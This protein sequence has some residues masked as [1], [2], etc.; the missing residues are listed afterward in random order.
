M[1]NNNT[2]QQGKKDSLENVTKKFNEIQLKL[3][4]V[5]GK[6]SFN[7]RIKANNSEMADIIEEIN[8][9]NKAEI[10]KT[11]KADFKILFAKRI[12]DERIIK[13]KQKEFDNEIIRLR[14]EYVVAA[15]SIL[16]KIDFVEESEIALEK[17]IDDLEFNDP[18]SI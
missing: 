4:K 2:N 9:E 14:K 17:A 7:N 10:L 1:D 11:I 5:F 16:S 13:Q 15:E 8:R 3:T 12:D 18:N 6:E